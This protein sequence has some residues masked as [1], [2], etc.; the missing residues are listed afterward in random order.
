[1]SAYESK[2]GTRRRALMIASGR[3]GGRGRSAAPDAA[4]ADAA[5]ADAAVE[6]AQRGDDRIVIVL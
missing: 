1:M 5:A 6:G 2:A 3:L 4:A